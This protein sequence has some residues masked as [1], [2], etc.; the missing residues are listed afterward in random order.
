MVFLGYADDDCVTGAALSLLRALDQWCAGGTI[1]CLSQAQNGFKTTGLAE[2]CEGAPGG[3]CP[4]TG[5]WKRSA[6]GWRLW[7]HVEPATSHDFRV[8]V[9]N[10][11]PSDRTP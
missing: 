1:M 4:T 2:R 5:W 9:W 11:Y 6:V 8:C 7:V 3:V 10:A